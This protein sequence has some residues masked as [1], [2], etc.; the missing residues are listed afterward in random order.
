MFS[1]DGFAALRSLH[2]DKAVWKI[3]D[4]EPVDRVA[5]IPIGR[6]VP[7]DVD[8]WDDYVAA[9]EVFGFEPQAREEERGPQV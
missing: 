7:L 1:A 8:T 3:V 2:G 5:R 6:S 4:G 9:C